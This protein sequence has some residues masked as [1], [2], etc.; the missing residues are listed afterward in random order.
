MA[1]RPDRA[2]PNGIEPHGQ[3]RRSFVYRKLAALGARFAAV[4]GGAIAMDFGKPEEE[5]SIA[6]RLGLADLS[7]LPRT[8]FK[9]AGA[10]EW[11]Q[12]Q[13]LDIGPESNRAYRQPGGEIALRLAPTEVLLVD[14]LNGPGALI[15][16]LDSAWSWGQE[17]PRH[18]IGYP[19]PR[20]DSH[21]WFAISGQETPEMFA[22]ICAIDFRLHKFADGQIAQTSVAKM[23][24]I[25]LRRDFGEIAGF[26]LLADSAAAEYLWECLL[27]AMAEFAGTPVGLG[28]LRSLG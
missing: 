9:G 18:P 4:N 16:R 3:L 11:L 26:H 27:D 2:E 17:R 28:A 14:S 12:S 8:G 24:G 1:A 5:L 15:D 6:R 19:M 25:V 7:P 13:G 10:V 20:A 21:A 22:K 23:N